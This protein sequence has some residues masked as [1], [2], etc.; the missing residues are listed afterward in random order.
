MS[1]SIIETDDLLVNETNDD[2]SNNN[3]NNNNVDMK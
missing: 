1:W 3:N 2:W